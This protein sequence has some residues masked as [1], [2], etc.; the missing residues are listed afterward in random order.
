MVGAVP[1]PQAIFYV[2]MEA[3]IYPREAPELAENID[4]A[5][6]E[7][8]Q[9]HETYGYYAQGVEP[10]TATLPDGWMARVHKI[11]N[12]NT[13]LKV[14]LCLGLPDLFLSKA[15]AAREKDRDFC[16]ALLEHGY[17]TLA[18]LLQLVSS[19]PID[20]GEQ[21]RLRATIRPLRFS[22]RAWP[23]KHSIAPVPGDFL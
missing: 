10:N 3:D 5:I 22:I 9:F 16:S 14:G 6:G 12:A 21:K 15:F 8:S 11:Q 23:M 4:G 7:G 19:M 2:S 13:D 18:P 17:V 1:K 20:E